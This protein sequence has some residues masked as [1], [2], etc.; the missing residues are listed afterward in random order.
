MTDRPMEPGSRAPDSSRF[1][2]EVAS[3]ERF[4]FGANW[5]AFLSRVNDER[6]AEAERSLADLLGTATLAGKSFLDV[7][8]GSGLFS[9]AARRLGAQVVSFDY[10]PESVACTEELKRRYAP[11]DPRWTIGRG[12]ALDEGFLRSLG[13]FD[14]VYSWGVLHHTGAMW[15]AMENVLGP[16]ARGGT[17]CIALYNDQGWKS[18]VWRRVKRFY[19]RGPLARG[20]ALSAYVPYYVL[21]GFVRDLRSGEPPLAGYLRYRSSRGMSVVHDW[22]DWL[23][24]YPFEVASRAAV[25]DFYEKRG[26]ALLREIP[27]DGSGC[28]QFVFTRPG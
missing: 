15:R 22:F 25:R 9:L 27:N 3:G 12:S 1:D 28:N 7:G 20:L 4:T 18:A 8:S 5:R 2:A 10:D 14:V 17:L 19:A 16:L 23:G 26:L 21:A 24:G 11:G 13:T 6:I